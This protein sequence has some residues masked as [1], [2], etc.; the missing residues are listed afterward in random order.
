MPTLPVN[1][2]ARHAIE[3][4]PGTANPRLLFVLLHDAGG[5]AAD[6]L[7]LGHRLG[8][9]FAGSAV[10]IPDGLVQAVDPGRSALPSQVARL[11]DYLRAQQQRFGVLQ[12][13]LALLG[14]G[15]GATLALAL[16][17]AHDGLA[18]RVLAF[19]GGYADWPAQAPALTT[20][21]FLHGQLDPDMPLARI[22][23]DFARLVA[24]GA[25]ATLDV[26]GALGH[27]LHP[28]L[29]DQAVTR[30]QTCVPLRFWKAL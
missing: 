4:L 16:S 12:S 14:F 18:G 3:L 6:M 5:A 21:H 28:A 29:M 11:A 15:V 10:L 20:L 8:A 27:E 1:P 23:Q 9:A 19:G 26:A 24:L 13:D 30:L 25:D 2:P 7:D 17:A 22:R